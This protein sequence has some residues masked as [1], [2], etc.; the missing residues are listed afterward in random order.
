MTNEP[1]FPFKLDNACFKSLEFYR[2]SKLPKQHEIP[3]TVALKVHDNDF[4]DRVQIDLRL[5]SAEDGPL[6]LCL[7]LIGLFT[8]VEDRPIPDQS[9]LLDFIN[10]QALHML[11]PYLNQA[12]RQITTMMGSNPVDIKTPSAFGFQRQEENEVTDTQ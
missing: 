2:E 7:E 12:V 11:W 1:R 3:I 4:P 5:E 9:V 8:L 6:R 10:E